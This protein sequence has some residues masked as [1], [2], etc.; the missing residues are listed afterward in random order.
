MSEPPTP[1]G[2]ERFL[3]EQIPLSKEMGV[4]VESLDACRLV[5]TAPLEPN[6][7]HLGTAFGGSLS[8]LA[9]LAGYGL[10]WLRLDDRSAHI[11]ILSSSI[12]YHQP[13]R[14]KLRAVCD[15]PEVKLAAFESHFVS[16]GRARIKLQVRIE[17]E[18]RT[19]VVFE[20][21]FAALT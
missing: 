1:A 6:H 2:T 19:C 10:L 12:H 3:H 5:L 11:I 16:K 20:G 14:G 15:S 21:V 18:G 7:N 4:R 8:A 9:M 13:V 17:E